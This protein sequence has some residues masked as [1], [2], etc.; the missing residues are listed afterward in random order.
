MMKKDVSW[1]KEAKI[2][3]R[4]L[5]TEDG[6]VPENSLLAFKRAMACNFA[7]E[8]DVNILNDGVVV[9][10]HDH[11]LRRLCGINRRL[12]EVRYDEIQSLRLLSSDEHIPT[13][14]DVLKLVDGKVPLLIELK[15]HGDV[16]RL[17]QGVMKS[18]AQYQG[19][20][21]IFS[22]HPRVV[23]WFRKHAP[24][25]IRGQIAEFFLNHPTMNVFG[26]W[27]M[28]HMVFNIFTKPDFISYGI[29]DLPNSILDRYKQKNMTIISYAA[30]SQ[31]EFD[32]VKSHYDN[33]VFEFFIPNQ[34]G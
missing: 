31:A 30:R 24:H 10:F 1:L 27:I 4:G 2:A 13:L 29:H 32:H 26:R 34:K 7:I 14:D 21:A 33:V 18:L 28:K 6:S 5:H 17:C 22:F 20:Y 12:S 8:L 15:P 16:L 25:V 3:H 11:D 19:T 23:Y 9:S